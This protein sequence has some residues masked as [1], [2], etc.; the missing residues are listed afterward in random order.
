LYRYRFLAVLAGAALAILSLA[1]ADRLLVRRVLPTYRYLLPPGSEVRYTTSE[2]E[3]VARINRCGL[4]EREFDLEKKD[5]FR[6]LTIGDSFTFGWGVNAEQS[7]PKLLEQKLAKSGRPVE[8]INAGAAGAGTLEYAEIAEEWISVLRPDL[9]LVAIHQGDDFGQAISPLPR[10]KPPLYR[11]GARFILSAVCP[12]L[13]RAWRTRH[14]RKPMSADM[15]VSWQR[16]ATAVLERMSPEQQKHFAAIDAQ[17]QQMFRDGDLNP[18]LV[19]LALVAPE[20]YA[21]TFDVDAE[22]PRL[23]AMV[24]HLERIRRAAEGQGTRIVVFS[25]PHGCY[26]TRDDYDNL[27]KIGFSVREDFVTSTAPD[28]VI[29]L[30]CER[31]QLEL[32]SVFADFRRAA[33]AERLF[34]AWDGHFTPAGNRVF[35]ELV[36]SQLPGL[37][38]PTR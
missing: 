37:V 2:F 3:W 12:N 7:W 38:S 20:H 13:W 33:S 9:V 19:D 10:P 29:R 6:I 28:D 31:A 5:A 34:F 26:V 8:V 11:R 17:V 36:F 24:G 4:R 21:R 15:R 35:A 18:A 16:D 32:R 27:R 23:E 25:V 1:F 30:A 22:R 14:L